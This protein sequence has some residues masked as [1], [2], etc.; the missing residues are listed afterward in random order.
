MGES[1]VSVRGLGKIWPGPVYALRSVDLEVGAGE[2]VVLLGANGS[3]KSTLLGVLAGLVRPSEGA[4][5]L[6]GVPVEAPESRARLGYAPETPAL[7]ARSTPHALLVAAARLSRCREAARR[8]T[9]A[10]NR[11]DLADAADRPIGTLSQG[12]RERVALA[13]AL[14]HGPDLIVLD[15]PLTGLDVDG[16]ARVV[17]VLR[18]ERA[19]GAALLVATH[20]PEAFAPLADRYVTLRDG[21]VESA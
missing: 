5:R 4:A 20:W 6:F 8:A 10:L 7:P 11:L 21:A 12:A 2:A 3:G 14:V 17:G 16:R 18:E 15:E 13:L 1:A 9:D 19:R